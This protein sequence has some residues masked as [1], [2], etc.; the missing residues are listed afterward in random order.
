MSKLRLFIAEKLL[1]LALSISP[2][3]E[4]GRILAKHIGAYAIE[5]HRKIKA[6]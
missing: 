5:A 2:H 6:L 1:N 3:N 4:D